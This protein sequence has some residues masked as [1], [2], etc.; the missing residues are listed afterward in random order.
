MIIT[1]TTVGYGDLSPKTNFGR[2][3][4]M[5]IAFWGMIFTSFFVVA[6]TNMLS[7]TENELNAYKL[8]MKLQ[9][10]N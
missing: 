1:L 5:L 7:F 2:I 4:G 9:Y 3:V 8:I 10:R 6:V